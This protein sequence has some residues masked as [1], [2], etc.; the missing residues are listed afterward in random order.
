MLIAVVLFLN[1]FLSLFLQVFIMGVIFAHAIQ[2]RLVFCTGAVTLSQANICRFEPWA[3][4]ATHTHT[5]RKESLYPRL[6]LGCGLY[7]IHRKETV[8]SMYKWE[9]LSDIVR[10]CQNLSETEIS[11]VVL[12]LL[13]AVSNI[14]KHWTVLTVKLLFI[15]K[16]NCQYGNIGWTIPV[17]S[18]DPHSCC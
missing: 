2:T 5:H 8:L 11:C 18:L 14:I 4:C 1:T 10:T 12:A 3:L 13:I 6:D 15:F 7:Q 16:I 9:K 17:I